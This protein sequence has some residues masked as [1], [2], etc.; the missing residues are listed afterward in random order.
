MV[1]EF[2]RLDYFKDRIILIDFEE[3]VWVQWIHYFDSVNLRRCLGH[4]Q[5]IA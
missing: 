2:I 4:M 3:N 5:Y 1:F